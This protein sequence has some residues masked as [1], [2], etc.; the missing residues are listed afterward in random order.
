MTSIESLNI[1]LAEFT[2]TLEK[3]SPGEVERERVVTMIKVI[4]FEADD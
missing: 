1:F 4:T 2:G 3:Q